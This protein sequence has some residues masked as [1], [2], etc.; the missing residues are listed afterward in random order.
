VTCNNILKEM[1]EPEKNTT[2][3][4]TLEGKP[5]L[6]GMQWIFNIGKYDG[7]FRRKSRKAIRCIS[8][9]KEAEKK[10]NVRLLWGLGT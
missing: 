2:V 7:K 4:R 10:I 1:V 5:E 6:L 9:P 3:W 8:F